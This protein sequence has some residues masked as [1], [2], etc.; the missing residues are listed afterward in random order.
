M[1]VIAKMCFEK[2][3]NYL[4]RGF[5][6]E[7]LVHQ[8]PHLRGVAFFEHQLLALGMVVGRAMRVACDKKRYLKRCGAQILKSRK[9]NTYYL[10]KICFLD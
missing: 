2:F 4:N 8:L 1:I 7:G 10:I 5:D 9:I 3:K 6:Q